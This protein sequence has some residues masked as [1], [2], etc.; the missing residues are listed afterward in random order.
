M[1]VWYKSSSR[2]SSF[3]LHSFFFFN[4]TFPISA[5]RR[6]TYTHPMVGSSSKSA[7]AAVMRA[8]S[9]AASM[10]SLKEHGIQ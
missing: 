1:P 6:L 9:A 5:F 2:A 4:F 8:T 3:V 10:S 7:A